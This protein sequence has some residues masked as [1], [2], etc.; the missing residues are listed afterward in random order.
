MANKTIQV[1]IAVLGGGPAGYTAALRSAQLGANVALIEQEAVGGTCLNQ[2]CIPT[3]TLLG[4]SGLMAELKHAREFGL[5]IQQAQINWDGALKQKDRVVKMLQ[6]GVVQLLK[7][8]GV[9]VIAGKGQVQSPERILVPTSE[10]TWEVECKKLILE[11]YTMSKKGKIIIAAAAAVLVI[12]AVI[13]ILV[14]SGRSDSESGSSSAAESS[15]ETETE[16]TTTSQTTTTTSATTTTT[17]ETATTTEQT[18][19][20]TTTSATT[21]Q[22]TT[23][24]APVPT[25]VQPTQKLTQ[26]QTQRTTT[27]AAPKPTSNNDNGGG[28]NADD[29]YDTDDWDDIDPG[30]WDIN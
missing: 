8:R 6:S 18:T 10:G 15:S 2:G 21:T 19:T 3:K 25:A 4:S 14:V 13:I 16:T 17:S 11:V 5:E 30:D 24:P 23:T 20:T 12:A 28:G 26:K 1:E 9:T 29:I 7:T 27:Q 22:Q